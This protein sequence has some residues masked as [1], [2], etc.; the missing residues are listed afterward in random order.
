MSTPS[1]R[2]LLVGHHSSGK[3]ALIERLQTDRF[4]P[5]Y[6]PTETSKSTNWSVSV[7]GTTHTVEIVDFPGQIEPNITSNSAVIVVYSVQSQESLDWA[8]NYIQRLQP[9]H[10]PQ[11][12]LAAT[13]ADSP[14]STVSPVHVATFTQRFNLKS[15]ETSAKSGENV[16]NCFEKACKLIL[17]KT[18]GF[19]VE[20]MKAA[21]SGLEEIDIFE[22]GNYTGSDSPPMALSPNSPFSWEGENEDAVMEEENH[23][24]EGEVYYHLI[25]E[26][27][28]KSEIS[29]QTETFEKRP[30]KPIKKGVVGNRKR[31]DKDK[32]WLRQFRRYIKKAYITLKIRMPP[33]ERSYW[34]IYLTPE[35]KP[36][37]GH[38]FKSYCDKYRTT[39]FESV[40]FRQRFGRWFTSEGEK[41]I[42][43]LKEQGKI[44]EETGA[45]FLEYAQEQLLPMCNQETTDVWTYA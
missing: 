16:Y 20:D 41:I 38:I 6:I 23:P 4:S 42:R 12:L 17:S 14:N 1:L 11:I 5:I 13:K 33:E 32:F 29:T 30:R 2:L 25:T 37:R 26:G 44:T 9:F 35:M 28:E 45:L 21:L 36:D 34:K 43:E 7:S 22:S 39:L 27:T 8:M 31:E 40:Y 3:T 19:S 15:I 18:Q 10:Y 24:Q